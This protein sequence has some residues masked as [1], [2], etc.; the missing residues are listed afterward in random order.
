MEKRNGLSFNCAESVL[1][2]VN[3]EN[4]L[5]GFDSTHMRI[6]SVL[7]GGIAGCGETCGAVSGGVI[8]LGLQFG[9]EG[10]E[11]AE[12]FRS[13]RE[14]ARSLVKVFVRD[15]EEAW[16]KVDCRTLRAMD[17]GEIPQQGNARPANPTGDL[18]SEYVKWSSERVRKI[19]TQTMVESNIEV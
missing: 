6:A 15:F 19:I 9:S 16:G 11:A 5:S 12:E 2:Q 14:H 1:L 8:C 13:K 3:E 4:P 18:C 10:N 7:G 17:T